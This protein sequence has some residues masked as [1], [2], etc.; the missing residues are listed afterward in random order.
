[1][2]IQDI[3]MRR[4]FSQ[5]NQAMGIQSLHDDVRRQCRNVPR[6]QKYRQ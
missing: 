6:F 2:L 4:R 3:L 1:V 5:N